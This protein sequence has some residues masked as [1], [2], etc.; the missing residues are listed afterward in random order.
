[1]RMELLDFWSSVCYHYGVMLNK[2]D[3]WLPLRIA[4]AILLLT[5]VTFGL[6]TLLIVGSPTPGGPE[7][8]PLVKVFKA[9]DTL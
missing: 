2:L 9:P 3:I 1:M 5:L 4:G 7:R 6:T 8:Q